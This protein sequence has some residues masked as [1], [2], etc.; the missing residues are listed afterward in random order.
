MVWEQNKT[1]QTK[2]GDTWR[3]DSRGITTWWIFNK[4]ELIIM[5]IRKTNGMAF[6]KGQNYGNGK[7]SN[8]FQGVGRGWVLGEGWIHE[9]PF[10]RW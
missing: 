1:K 6:W 2:K 7:K 5:L 9:T 10:G 8:G 3:T 4:C